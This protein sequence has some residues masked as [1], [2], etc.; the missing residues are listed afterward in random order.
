[1]KTLRRSLVWFRRD[2]RLRDNPAL[3]AAVAESNQLTTVYIH[4]PE[5]ESPWAPGAASRWYL[6]QSL[7]VL[8]QVLH[9]QNQ[10]LI[11]GSDSSLE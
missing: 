5:E 11:F 3:A 10:S 6:Y 8:Q 1:M 4:A 9:K 2:L 7:R